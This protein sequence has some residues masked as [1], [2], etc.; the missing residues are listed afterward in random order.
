MYA[1]FD[2]RYCSEHIVT[3]G[4]P[5]VQDDPRILLLVLE[6]KILARMHA[7]IVER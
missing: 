2:M 4:S 3:S 1:L 6:L 7:L 5:S